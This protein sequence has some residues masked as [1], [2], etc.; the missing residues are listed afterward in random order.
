MSWLLIAGQLNASDPCNPNRK[1]CGRI[2]IYIG[3][4]GDA[5]S[6][7][8]GVKGVDADLNNVNANYTY[9][10]FHQFRGTDINGMPS[11]SIVIENDP[12]L[13][14]KLENL[15]QAVKDDSH[16]LGIKPAT[17]DSFQDLLSTDKKLSLIEQ[18]L[19]NFRRNSD[20]QKLAVR[21]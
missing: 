18:A 13:K 17:Y 20:C 1:F 2:T 8:K 4:A 19:D 11:Y 10:N 5:S 12:K 14:R 6:L 9:S 3:G 7:T 21:K 16:F 15:P